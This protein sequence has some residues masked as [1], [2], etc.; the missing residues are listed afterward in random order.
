MLVKFNS[1]SYHNE[2]LYDII[3]M[4]ACH[5]LLWR[6]WQFDKRAIHDGHANTYSLTKN[7]VGHK[8]NPLKDIEEK[9]CRNA[10]IFLVDRRK[11]LDGMR[12]EKMH[13]L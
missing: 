7:G 13:F 4:D 6:S 8:L 2:V 10:T 1:R 11:F 9:V 5:M 12:H 3:P